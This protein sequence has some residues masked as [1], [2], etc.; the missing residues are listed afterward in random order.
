[1]HVTHSFQQTSQLLLDGLS[2]FCHPTHLLPL[3]CPFI[4]LLFNL[5]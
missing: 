5:T 2:L 4:H 3:L 1:M